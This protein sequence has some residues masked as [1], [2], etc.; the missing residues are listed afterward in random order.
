MIPGDVVKCRPE[1]GRPFLA[2]LQRVDPDGT[3]H[4]ATRWTLA[5][6]D[7]PYRGQARAFPADRVTEPTAAE[8][9][10]IPTR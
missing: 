1:R 9:R 3:H 4:V 5:G 7:H 6:A 2:V 8:H 10:K